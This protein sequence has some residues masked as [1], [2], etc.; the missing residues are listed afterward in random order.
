MAIDTARMGDAV[1]R[2][3]GRPATVYGAAGPTYNVKGV[4]HERYVSDDL[5]VGVEIPR[6]T[7]FPA[8]SDWAKTEAKAGD[9][10]VI[11]TCL[12]T[13]IDVQP[14]DGG[15]VRVTLQ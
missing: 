9:Q 4:F 7:F 2:A 6:P 13:V 1:A 3:L 11:G 15:L 12:Y 8:A 5:G 14:S 10:V